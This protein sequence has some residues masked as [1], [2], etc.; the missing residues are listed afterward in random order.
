MKALQLR[1]PASCRILQLGLLLPV[2]VQDVRLRCVVMQPVTREQESS[3]PAAD[4][5]CS[6]LFLL[7]RSMKPKILTHCNFNTIFRKFNST[8]AADGD[9]PNFPAALH[10]SSAFRRL[11]LFAAAH[12]YRRRR[13]NHRRC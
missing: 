2:G 11:A 9:V 7:V 12:R 6:I 5:V 10:N 1:A 13:H 4:S 8:D 3:S